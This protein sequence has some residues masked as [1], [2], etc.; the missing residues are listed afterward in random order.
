MEV[1]TSLLLFYF[2]PLLNVCCCYCRLLVDLLHTVPTFL[3]ARFSDD[4][5]IETL[6]TFTAFRPMPVSSLETDNDAAIIIFWFLLLFILNKFCSARKSGAKAGTKEAK[7]KHQATT[8]K[9]VD[10]DFVDNMKVM[11]S[12]DLPDQ[13]DTIAWKQ[14]FK[15]H[16]YSK[17]YY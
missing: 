9:E 17:P 10:S 8:E 4:R 5:Q 16:I 11:L 7:V 13:N 2:H 3:E 1:P 12:M 6:G 15:T 14:F